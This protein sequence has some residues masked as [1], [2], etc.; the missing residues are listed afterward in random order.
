MKNKRYKIGLALSGGGA[1][2]FAH[3]GAL[4]ALEE[5]GLKPDV[6]SGTSAGAIAGSMYCAGVDPFTIAE[7]FMGKEFTEFAKFSF[8]RTGLFNH[9]PLLDFIRR[10]L[11]GKSFENLDIP[12]HIVTGDPIM[13][14]A[15]S[16]HKVI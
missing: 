12:I 13:G 14:K 16:L 9:E 5:F 10:S 4:L 7:S 2:G 1:R 6:V 8:P 3:C 11:N 15:L